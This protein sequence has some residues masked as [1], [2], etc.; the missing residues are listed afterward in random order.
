M[1]PDS[2]HL[3]LLL[4]SPFVAARFVEG[5]W[6]ITFLDLAG[7]VPQV[8]INATGSATEQYHLAPIAGAIGAVTTQ[9]EAVREASA[10]CCVGGNFSLSFDGLVTAD[11]DLVDIEGASSDYLMEILGDVI[12]E[13]KCKR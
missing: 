10:A 12:D 6:T 4:L 8:S 5:R 9:V 1:Y 7:N 3:L 2:A 11:V 13:G